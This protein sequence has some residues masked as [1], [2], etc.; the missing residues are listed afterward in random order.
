VGDKTLTYAGIVVFCDIIIQD[1]WKLWGR[2]HLCDKEG[3]ILHDT[4]INKP[5]DII[6]DETSY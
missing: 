3:K 4:S 2:E 1:K 6:Y 5:K